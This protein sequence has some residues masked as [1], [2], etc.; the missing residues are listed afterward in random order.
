MAGSRAVG[1]DGRVAG[2]KR[3][4]A[5]A[6][7]EQFLDRLVAV[8]DEWPVSV[9][10]EVYVF[11]SFARGALE[12]A[13][14]DIDVEFDTTNRQFAVA[15]AQ[16]LSSGRDPHGEL[17][18]ALVG[19]SRGCQLVY[20]MRDRADF[21]LTL[22]WRRGED[23]SDAL[24]R[25]QAMAPDQSATRAPRD[26]M[27]PEFEGIDRWLPR[28]V[29]EQLVEAV[30]EG[31]IRLERCVLPD[32]PVTGEQ[33]DR[34]LRRRWTTS[35]ALYRA[36]RAVLAFF[37]DR[38]IDPGQVHLHGQDVRDE[39]TPYFAGLGLRYFSSAPRCL[40]EYDGVEWV[41][42]VHPSLRG[43]LHAL[44]VLPGDRERLRQLRW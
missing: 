24:R 14:V 2:V 30:G 8:K 42:V 1:G 33:T 35:G 44:R 9:V 19:R 3:Q 40:V 41:E 38:G 17:R 39:V 7:I 43:E 26:A 36:G 23:P 15:R 27:L 16:A 4:R 21:E 31:A 12:P 5:V 34:Y 10:T 28:P 6:L 22:L 20:N 11:G 29:R 13:D 25:L 18:R 32:M 37:E